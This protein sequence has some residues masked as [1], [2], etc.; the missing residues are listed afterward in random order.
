MKR[1]LILIILLCVTTSI[2]QNYD[3][4]PRATLQA[5]V[6]VIE[7]GEQ[8]D[9]AQ[10]LPE[11]EGFI[12]YCLSGP[13]EIPSNT[14]R[15]QGELHFLSP[16]MM[17][18]WIPADDGF[19][20]QLD[21]L[22]GGV[23]AAT[24][25]ESG[26]EAFYVPPGATLPQCTKL[27]DI[28]PFEFVT[29]AETTE[30]LDTLMYLNLCGHLYV[31][32]DEGITPV[33]HAIL[34]DPPPARL[35]QIVKLDSHSTTDTGWTPLMYA[36][37]ENNTEAIRALIEI[38]AFPAATT[39]DGTSA[40]S[41]APHNQLLIDAANRPWSTLSINFEDDLFE[42]LKMAINFWPFNR[43][44]EGFQD[45]R[46]SSDN[47]RVQLRCEQQTQHHDIVL[48]GVFAFFNSDI[49]VNYRF[50]GGD[51]NPSIST[52][53][54]MQATAPFVPEEQLTTFVD[55]LVKHDTLHLRIRSGEGHQ[56]I[57]QY[58]LQEFT[59]YLAERFNT[60]TR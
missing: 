34:T 37:Q 29:T 53:V 41:L 13:L 4:D 24:L 48:Y 21:L 6:D 16:N 3:P 49:E 47:T 60:C 31:R 50:E 25:W 20:L 10:P 42:G 35:S 58:N 9:C 55:Q 5:L 12:E 44:V 39:E 33:I 2:A 22:N 40:L 23:I 52:R 30:D 56:A 54:D 36:A 19:Q 57:M 26:M 51:L 59:P 46:F 38:G 43:T 28:D 11:N 14:T 27:A 1:P 8:I 18:K 32:N 15:V 45:E 17:H 7:G